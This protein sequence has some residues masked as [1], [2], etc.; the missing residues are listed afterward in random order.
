MG[1]REREGAGGPA[2]TVILVVEDDPAVRQAAVWVLQLFG[3][4]TREAEDGPSAL[5]VLGKEPAIGLMFSDLVMPRAMNGIE[6][7][8][9]ARRR[10]PGLKVLLTT[11][12]SQADIDAALLGQAGIGLI[13]KPYS[14]NDLKEK[15]RAILAGLPA[16]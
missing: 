2:K 7:A 14:N 16:P 6:L 10:R 8:R 13:T 15:V 1:S 12:Y 3:Y 11:G 5:D 9:E 4:D